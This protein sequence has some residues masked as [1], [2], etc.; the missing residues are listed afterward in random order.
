VRDY[1]NAFVNRLLQMQ[2]VFAS[3]PADSSVEQRLQGWREAAPRYDVNATGPTAPPAADERGRKRSRGGRSDKWRQLSAVHSD[4]LLAAVRA[5]LESW[6]KANSLAD[7]LTQLN[8]QMGT[9]G[10]AAMEPATVLECLGVV[11]VSSP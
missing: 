7:V 6:P 1:H 10:L 4:L 9:L 5:L 2:E 11:M 8:G 3:L